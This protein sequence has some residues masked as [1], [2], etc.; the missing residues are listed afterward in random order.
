M[1]KISKAAKNH[2]YK[3]LLCCKDKIVSQKQDAQTRNFL[4]K[5][6]PLM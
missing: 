2:R 3:F 4:L 6:I 5:F 1:I